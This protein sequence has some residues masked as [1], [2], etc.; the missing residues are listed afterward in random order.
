M[1][2]GIFLLIIFATYSLCDFQSLGS[3]SGSIR[4]QENTFD[5]LMGDHL[6]EVKPI[7]ER[8]SKTDQNSVE[9]GFESI[10][11]VNKEENSQE[12]KISENSII[13]TST[14][15]AME[16]G[17]PLSDFGSSRLLK[18][19]DNKVHVIIG[20]HTSLLSNSYEYKTY[21]KE[22]DSKIVREIPEIDALV[23]DVQIS[24]LKY[25]LSIWNDLP[26]VRYVE[27]SQITSVSATTNDP[28]WNTQYGPKIIQ[29]DLA[30]DI[31][32]GDPTSVLVAVIDTGIDYDHPDL[33]DQYITGGYDYVNDDTDPWDDHSHGTHCAG[34]IGATIN[35]SVG[36]AGVANVSIMAYKVFDSGG[37]GF[38]YDAASAI[39]NATDKGA[40]VLSNSY[41]FPSA[42][43]V[44]E[45]AVAYA[46]AN[47]VVIVVSAGNSG[48]PVSGYP[49][50]Y[51]ETITVSATDDTDTPASFT[52]YGGV[53]DVSAPGVD[54]WSTIPVSM[55]SYGYKSGTSMACPHVAG[56]VALIR[57]EFPTFTADQVRQ[58]LQNSA[59]DLGPVGWDEYYGHGRVNAFKAV[60]PPPEHELITYLQNIPEA[61]L[62]DDTVN[63][64]ASVFN[65]GQSNETDITLQLWINGTL[66]KEQ[67]NLSL[68]IGDNGTFYYSWTPSI[69]GEYNIT[70][71]TLPVLNET[72]FI[73]NRITKI[74]QVTQPIISYNLGDFIEI[75]L[76]EDGSPLWNFTYVSEIDETHVRIDFKDIM[77]SWIRVNT[78]TRLITA[79]TIWVGSYYIGQIETDLSIGDT[80]KWYTTTAKVNGTIYYNWNGM[81]LE[82]WNTSIGNEA[83]AYFDKSTGI[84]L[85]YNEMGIEFEM[86]NTSFIEWTPPDH[87]LQVFLTHPGITPINTEVL[88]NVSVHNGGLNN[89]TNIETQLWINDSMVNS[90]VFPSLL[91]DK[92]ATFSYPWTP[93]LNGS[94]N[95]TAYVVPVVN[96]TLLDNNI[97]SDF[98]LVK[99]PGDYLI[100]QDAFPWKYFW[101]PIM[102]TLGISY[103]VTSSSAFGGTNLSLYDRVVIPSDQP[104]EFYNR[105][106]DHLSWL[107][108]YV[109]R[110]GILEIHA[111]DQGDN[112]GS[113]I[114]DLPNGVGYVTFNQDIVNIEDPTNLL[115]YLPHIITPNDLILWGPSVGGYLTNV[116]NANVVLSDYSE[117][118]LIELSVGQG[119]YLI[120]TQTLELAYSEGESLFFENL[121]QYNPV[122]PDHEIGVALE[123]VPYLAN[124]TTLLIN[125]S[126][127][128]RGSSNESN[129]KFQLW[130]N[131]TLVINSSYST[132]NAGVTEIIQYE[133]TPSE[134]GLYNITA[135]APQLIDEITALN[136]HIQK[137]STV[138]YIVNYSIYEAGFNWFDAYSNGYNSNM[139]GDDTS[140]TL[141]L[142]FSFFFYDTNFSTVYISSNGYL[143]F[144]DSTPYTYSNPIFPTL[145]YPYSIAI[146]WDDLIA[147]E[148]VYIW[149]TSS[150][151][152][153]E[154]HNYT[155]L[156]G[157]PIGNFELILFPNGTIVM[158]YQ[159]ILT[160]QGA[161]IGLNYGIDLTYYSSYSER[162]NGIDELR[163]LFSSQPLVR[164]E[165]STLLEAPTAV[166]YNE[167]M[168]VI[169]NTTVSNKGTFNETN[170]IHQ[171]WINDS[172]V[173]EENITSLLSGSSIGF[174]YE[175]NPSIRANYN[176]TA[177]TFPVSNETYTENN[178]KNLLLIIDNP[179]LHF[180]LGDHI[181]LN[182]T[183]G[184]TESPWITFTYQSMIDSTHVYV[185]ASI[186]GGFV[187]EWMSVNVITGLVED[188]TIWVGM[189]YI[190][191]I[192]T[193]LTQGE[194]VQWL[195]ADGTVMGT[196]WYPWNGAT[197]EAWNISLNNQYPEMNLYYDK[198][199]GILI[200]MNDSASDSQYYIPSTSI[201]TLLSPTVSILYPV[202]GNIVS[203][204]ITINWT[205]HDPDNGSLNFTLNYWNGSEWVPLVVQTN[206]MNCSWN[207]SSVIDGN[208]YRLQL[209]VSDGYFMQENVTSTTFTVNNIE[210]PPTVQLL[211]P[212][213]GEN[214]TGTVIISWIASDPDN[215]ILTYDLYYWYEDTW[216]IIV[217]GTTNSTFVWD[218]IGLSDGN[219][220]LIRVLVMDGNFT[221]ED[222]S[223][224]VFTIDNPHPPTVNLTFPYSNGPFNNSVLV[225]WD[226]SDTDNDSLTYSLSYWNGI[227][228]IEIISGLT[229]EFYNWN[230]SDLPDGD[231]YQLKIIVNDG[232]LTGE[233]QSTLVFTIDNPHP[234]TVNLTF[235]YSN[236]PFNSSVLV[237][238][239]ASDADNDSLTY[240]LSY[241]NGVAWTVITSGLTTESYLWNISNLPNGDYYKLQIIVRDGNLTGEDQSETPFEIF[242]QQ[243][244]T[245]TTQTT[246]IT[247]TTT[248]IS[249]NPPISST[250]SSTT[251]KTSIITTTKR[252]IG[253]EWI[254]SLLFGILL[255]SRRFIKR[256]QK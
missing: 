154:Y 150:F 149:N 241:W 256:R 148:N 94:Y 194:T 5:R 67:T 125:A 249:T 189:Y 4:S 224:L 221:R 99:E 238:W 104:Q 191:Q 153:I 36:I 192:E 51:L 31:Q 87:D 113:W 242:N 205:G 217:I 68:D 77:N 13:K 155:F 247:T 131:N 45:D 160:D 92:S 170:I 112:D 21:L 70:A 146:F 49:A 162:L 233:D 171:L 103:D 114:G 161:T 82:A 14:K 177:M 71:Y 187:T 212:N 138:K 204:I 37:Y 248:T 100:L 197:L 11:P 96:D 195:D 200:F 227:A 139:S 102:D 180:S 86:T 32:K 69:L 135:Y 95:V 215:D 59:D 44:L 137:S 12:T 159:N 129:V 179:R 97:V 128:N 98:V 165:L 127:V 190:G 116:S 39:I 6:P 126:L 119:Y 64:S 35:N 93:D 84:M 133:W 178:K 142:P 163:L 232:S 222:Q 173:L 231:Y 226:A 61:I 52:S 53:V 145:G 228:W 202:S 237:T 109:Q 167:T 181:E 218:T 90:Q 210:D 144:N 219:E 166:L 40:A 41:G 9:L 143:S 79:G 140:Y 225:T 151:V 107:E 245:T 101:T 43:Q 88:L 23:V 47:D 83:F 17:I 26:F 25:F 255:G 176:L 54:I 244:S 250:L 65:Y 164:H 85:Y 216:N 209:I 141:D 105:I 121:L 235:P 130:I 157:T 46:L 19:T 108:S 111:A 186:L 243:I 63:I 220:Y 10:I 15:V 24:Q 73:N 2:R 193:E 152:A 207:T 236:G 122:P 214:L 254:F 183:S 28:D 22:T 27:L 91:K 211:Y 213:G 188:G 156:G 182:T 169:I 230:I 206:L 50:L 78:L 198:V 239:D 172:L 60:Q 76:V 199:T 124:G 7:Q 196:V 136:N 74:L 174:S 55:G 229:A 234:P 81:L 147:E 18:V 80:F 58:H 185:E 120:S 118:L 203:G 66:V 29:T 240:T 42:D 115:M 201:I 223:T 110:G 48:A 62:P 20:L 132:L 208:F 252:S 246:I 3:L 123:T 34:T 253:F 30:W 251:S 16:A 33:V 38:D 184:G 8:S 75:T 56:V 117:P 89:E 168:S 158:Q 134:I 106:N 72:F 57:S 1:I 175:W